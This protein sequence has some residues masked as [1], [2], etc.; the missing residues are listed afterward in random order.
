MTVPT[1]RWHRFLL[2][3]GVSILTIAVATFA[4][5]AVGFAVA[6]PIGF[7]AIAWY[8]D[9]NLG[10]CLPLAVMFLVVVAVLMT[11]LGLLVVT[12]PR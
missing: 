8:G 4:F 2:A 1:T 10:T 3:S 7:L 5:G 9:D 6:A 11:V 12:R